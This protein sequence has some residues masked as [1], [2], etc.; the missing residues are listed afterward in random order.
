MT[1]DNHNTPP[2]K[3]TVQLAL[4]HRWGGMLLGLCRKEKKKCLKDMKKRPFT[5]APGKF[6][7]NIMRI[8]VMDEIMCQ[9]EP[10]VKVKERKQDLEPW[11]GESTDTSDS[12]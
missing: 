10:Q 3:R 11:Q 7:A 9:L 12:E 4:T 8:K 5:P 2:E 1:K 6:D